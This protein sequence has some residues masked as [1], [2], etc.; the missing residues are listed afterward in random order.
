MHITRKQNDRIKAMKAAGWK[1]DLKLP[2]N[3][4]VLMVK[5]GSSV[6]ITVSGAVKTNFRIPSVNS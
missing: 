3:R 1:A 6:A 2:N 5:D 4:L